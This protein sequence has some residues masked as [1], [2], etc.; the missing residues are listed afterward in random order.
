[1]QHVGG[2]HELYLASVEPLDATADL[3]LP[4]LL[5]VFVRRLGALEQLEGEREPIVG[6]K[7]E[8]H[9][10]GLCERHRRQDSTGMGHGSPSPWRACR[11][12]G[13]S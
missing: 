1:M 3:G 10:A 4:G 11:R 5:G 13:R 6:R 9:G 2:G 8:R 7:R 12:S